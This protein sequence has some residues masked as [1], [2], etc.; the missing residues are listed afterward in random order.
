MRP[1]CL[2][3]QNTGFGSSCPQ[4]LPALIIQVFDHA[5]GQQVV[6]W[7]I[8]WKKKMCL[9][10]WTTEKIYFRWSQCLQLFIWYIIL[11]FFCLVLLMCPMTVMRRQI[12]VKWIWYVI[13]LVLVPVSS[14]N[15][16]CKW[17][18]G[19]PLEWMPVLSPNQLDLSKASTWHLYLF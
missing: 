14:F 17:G 13:S 9:K 11:S 12:T 1:A 7:E 3:N 2:A 6:S 15:I 18:R 10:A 4:A 8:R 5:Q 16:R 19:L